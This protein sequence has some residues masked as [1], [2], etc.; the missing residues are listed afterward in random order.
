MSLRCYIGFYGNFSG[1]YGGSSGFYGDSSGFYDNKRGCK[2]G[3]YY[4]Y[5]LGI[6][7]IQGI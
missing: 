3:R 4:V 5:I 1:F 7:E 2:E 6:L